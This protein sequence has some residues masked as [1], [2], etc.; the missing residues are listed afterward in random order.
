MDIKR[1][2]RP[3]KSGLAMTN[4]DNDKDIRVTMITD[5]TLMMT[6]NFQIL[7]SIGSHL[8]FVIVRLDPLAAA[9]RRMNRTIQNFLKELDSPI[10]SGN[11]S[12]GKLCSLFLRQGSKYLFIIVYLILF[13]SGVA[14]SSNVPPD[15]H[16]YD[17]LQRLEA[18]GLIKSSILTTKPLSRQEILRLVLEAE[19]NADESSPFLQGLIQSLK[20]RFQHDREEKRFIKPLSDPYTEYTYADSE[21]ADRLAYNNDGYDYKKGS[22]LRMGFTSEAGLGRASMHLDPELRNNDDD[23]ELQL[24]RAY[25]IFS[26]AGIDLEIGKDSQWW[27]P[28]HHGS[29]LLSNNAEPFILVKLSNAEPV[30]LPSILRYLGLFKFTFFTTRLGDERVI[31]EPYLWGMRINLKLNP[32]IEIGLQR[33]A[34]LGGEG[35]SS[36]L[37]TWLKSFAGRGEN[38]TGSGAGDQ[39]A[40]VDL[41]VTIPFRWQP[42]QLYID[43]A[44]EDEANHFPSNWAYLAG[45]Y[46]PRILSLERFDFRA[47]YSTNHIENKPNVWYNHGV[48]RSGYTYKGEIIGHHMGTDSRDLFFEAGYVMPYMNNAKASVSY[49]REEHNLSDDVHE[50]KDELSLSVEATGV[51][52]IFLET[53]YNYGRIANFE[54]TEG[55]EKRINI[56]MLNIIYW[57]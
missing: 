14:F 35:R 26:L 13:S 48:Y 46:F 5:D 25:G 28:G 8:K 43:G 21:Y 38:E 29:I 24:N 55:E 12:R 40:G 54:Q 49:N 17:I 57:F 36:D 34:L 18:E 9:L 15:D 32:Y 51:K 16:V 33:T 3:E 39:R 1:S 27:G 44:G 7:S 52:N 37:T 23:T 22:N 31:S 56:F 6:S 2:P 10:K 41:K 50:T 20:E 53:E 19:G 11:D 42:M 4:T 30:I 45:I 47:E